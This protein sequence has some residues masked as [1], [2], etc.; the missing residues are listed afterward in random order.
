MKSL[1][2]LGIGLSLV[3]YCLLLALVVELCYLL[4]WNVIHFGFSCSR[5]IVWTLKTLR[6]FYLSL[7]VLICIYWSRWSSQ[8]ASS[9]Q[10]SD[11][12]FADTLEFWFSFCM[13]WFA[14]DHHKVHMLDFS[15]LIEI[16]EFL[17]FILLL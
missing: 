1:S 14:N 11:L 10:R 17:V 7:F 12:R 8:L 16:H 3:F 4:W 13:V 9:Y 2:S 5:S 6:D 15:V